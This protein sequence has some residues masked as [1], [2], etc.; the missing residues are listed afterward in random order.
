MSSI[1]TPTPCMNLYFIYSYWL[2]YL[3]SRSNECHSFERHSNDI[4]A[5][6]HDHHYK[7][8][9][10][11]GL[12]LLRNSEKSTLHNFT[13]LQLPSTLFTCMHLHHDACKLPLLTHCR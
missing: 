8:G 13:L 1:F 12:G 10:H 4:R 11:R 5:I 6:P 7:F 9:N 2:K 3:T